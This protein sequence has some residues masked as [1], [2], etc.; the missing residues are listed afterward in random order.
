MKINEKIN[1]NC[2]KCEYA[3]TY[4]HDGTKVLICSNSRSMNDGR[5][6]FKAYESCNDYVGRASKNSRKYNKKINYLFCKTCNITLPDFEDIDAHQDHELY[7][8]VDLKHLHEM[9]DMY[10]SAGD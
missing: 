10:L 3:A 2:E 4:K 8:D 7:V 1:S 6:F 9:A 5:V